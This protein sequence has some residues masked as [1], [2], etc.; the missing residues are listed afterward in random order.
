MQEKARLRF[1]SGVAAVAFPATLQ[2]QA[3]LHVTIVA[4][5]VLEMIFGKNWSS[6]SVRHVLLCGLFFSLPHT[7]AARSALRSPAPSELT[8]KPSPTKKVSSQDDS[9]TLVPAKDLA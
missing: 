7:A 2:A 5:T 3:G 1:T 6:A 9:F 4:V 8:A